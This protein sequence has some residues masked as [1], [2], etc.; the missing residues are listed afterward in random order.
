MRKHNSSPYASK[1]TLKVMLDWKTMNSST[2]K[3]LLVHQSTSPSLL[4]QQHKLSF[5]MMIV[6]FSIVFCTTQHIT[7][8]KTDVMVDFE[9]HNSSVPEGN[10]VDIC[11]ILVGVTEVNVSVSLIVQEETASML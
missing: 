7:L 1:S 8:S 6:R 5:S 2:L 3:Y 10:S 11:L 4:I 9:T